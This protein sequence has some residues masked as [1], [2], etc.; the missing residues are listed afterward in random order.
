MGLTYTRFLKSHARLLL[1][2]HIFTCVY[3]TCIHIHVHWHSLVTTPSQSLATTNIVTHSYTCTIAHLTY[4]FVCT[5]SR[6]HTCARIHTSS[7]IHL[8]SNTHIFIRL[9]ICIHARLHPPIHLYSPHT[10][11]RPVISSSTNTFALNQIVKNAYAC[12]DAHLHTLIHLHLRTSSHTITL[13]S[14]QIFT[15]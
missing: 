9:N 11:L 8:R 15:H 5:C 1:S 10:D 13:V 2:T 14:T 7:Y 6:P 12:T 4:I 3:T